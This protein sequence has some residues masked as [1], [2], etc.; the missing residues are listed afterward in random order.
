MYDS[1]ELVKVCTYFFLKISLV[2]EFVA[3]ALLL[4]LNHKNTLTS[5][6]LFFLSQM[7]IDF[8][9]PISFMD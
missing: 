8:V 4:R 3:A 6:L 9:T 2:L 7:Q 1:Y 5:V